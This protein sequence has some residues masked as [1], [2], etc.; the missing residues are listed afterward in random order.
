MRSDLLILINYCLVP[1]MVIVEKE[2][3]SK[4]KE[5]QP[6]SEIVHDY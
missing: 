2:N 1:L 5:P 4:V 6:F 3:R